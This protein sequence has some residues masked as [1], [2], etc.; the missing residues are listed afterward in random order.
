MMMT[1]HAL[2][3]AALLVS[4]TLA[5]STMVLAQALP[6][7]PQQLQQ[8]HDQTIQNQSNAAHG[9]MTQL[10]IQQPAQPQPHITPSGRAVSHPPGWI[11]MPH[12]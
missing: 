12:K 6:P 4:S 3:F 2:V 7:T 10:Q 1:K 8:Q 11:P 9:N 5:G